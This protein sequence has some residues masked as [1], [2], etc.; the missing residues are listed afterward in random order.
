MDKVEDIILDLFT[1]SKEYL[2]I[3][4]YI[5]TAGIAITLTLL[6]MRADNESLISKKNIIFDGI[7]AFRDKYGDV[8]TGGERL[9]FDGD[10]DEPEV[11]EPTQEQESEP[12]EEPQQS[13]GTAKTLTKDAFA[14]VRE[15]IGEL[16]STDEED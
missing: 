12:A 10:E 4:N 13:H 14:K 15:K 5:D 1:Q 16:L 11:D 8:S 7:Q 3:V 9:H 2:D 6:K